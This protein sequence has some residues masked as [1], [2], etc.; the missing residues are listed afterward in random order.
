MFTITGLP[1]SYFHFVAPSSCKRNLSSWQKKCLLQTGRFLFAFVFLDLDPLFDILCA[2]LEALFTAEFPVICFHHLTPYLCK[3]PPTL[4]VTSHEPP[5]LPWRLR[6]PGV[7]PRECNVCWV[8]VYMLRSVSHTGV[9]AQSKHIADDFKCFWGSP[10]WA[11]KYTET[12]CCSNTLIEPSG[13]FHFNYKRLKLGLRATLVSSGSEASA[14]GLP[15]A[16]EK[17]ITHRWRL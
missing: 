17:R 11:W 2:R 15:L 16:Q 8:S 5:R 10:H 3:G 4:W 6:L 1:L 12:S 14:A 13:S 9:R 7:V